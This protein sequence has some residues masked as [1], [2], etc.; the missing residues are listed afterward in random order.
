MN[1]DIRSKP[2]MPVYKCPCLGTIERQMKQSTFLPGVHSSMI[3]NRVTVR[4]KF[5]AIHVHQGSRSI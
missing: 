2:A 5:K 1:A 3:P 4:I